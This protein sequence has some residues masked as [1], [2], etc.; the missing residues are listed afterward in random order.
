MLF[1]H[2]V[3]VEPTCTYHKHS[4]KRLVNLNKKENPPFSFSQYTPS[5]I[6]KIT[7]DPL[8]LFPLRGW[9]GGGGIK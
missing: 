4:H 5:N 2:N 9:R 7:N 8:F 6:S 3:H 1:P